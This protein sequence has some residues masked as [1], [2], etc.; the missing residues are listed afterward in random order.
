MHQVIC[1]FHFLFWH[2]HCSEPTFTLLWHRSLAG[3]RCDTREVLWRDTASASLLLHPPASPAAGHVKVQQ[4]EVTM[5]SPEGHYRPYSSQ[6]SRDRR[7]RRPPEPV[8]EIEDSETYILLQGEGRQGP[9]FPLQESSSRAETPGSQSSHRRTLSS[10]RDSSGIRTPGSQRDGGV[11]GLGSQ[12][13]GGVRTPGS[14]RDGGSRTPGSQR[15]G[16]RSPGS[17]RTVRREDLGRRSSSQRRMEEPPSPTSSWR[18]RGI[19]VAPSSSL[20]TSLTS[21]VSQREQHAALVQ[22]SPRPLIKKQK[23]DPSCICRL[24]SVF[25]V[26]TPEKLP[27]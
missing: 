1:F 8:S 2:H 23:K 19:P 16:R 6:K 22:V 10:H 4:L 12:R 5:Y 14:Q 11:R 15:E 18:S 21:Q 26:R 20:L 9:S 13:D 3:A 27:F 24:P 17:Q 7:Q 25:K